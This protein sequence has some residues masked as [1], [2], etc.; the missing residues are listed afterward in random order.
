MTGTIK[1][2]T[3]LS[4]S[5][6]IHPVRLPECRECA[7]PFQ[8]LGRCRPGQ[9]SMRES[10]L[11]E[12]THDSHPRVATPIMSWPRKPKLGDTSDF[13]PDKTKTNKSVC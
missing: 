2:T 10:P 11:G 5:V 13:L 12:M 7:G 4:L 9:V 1:H 8:R 3:G 6:I